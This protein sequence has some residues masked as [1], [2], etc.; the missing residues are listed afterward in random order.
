M[1]E[2]KKIKE[3]R[4]MGVPSSY[5]IGL[6]YISSFVPRYFELNHLTQGCNGLT[7][8]NLY[9]TAIAPFMSYLCLDAN[10]SMPQRAIVPP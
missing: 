7:L 4:E 5:L 8:G 10:S 1:T 6:L 2:N 3:V 9:P